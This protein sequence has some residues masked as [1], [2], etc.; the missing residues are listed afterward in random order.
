MQVKIRLLISA[1]HNSDVPRSYL[2]VLQR[3]AAGIC[4]S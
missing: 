4:D 2:A 1:V 3:R